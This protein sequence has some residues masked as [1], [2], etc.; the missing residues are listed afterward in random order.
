MVYIEQPVGV[1]FSYS[2][3][4]SDYTMGD[5]STA[6]DT[7]AALLQFFAR[8]PQY[9]GRPFYITGESYGGH[10]VPTL[11]TAIIAYNAA[12]PGSPINMAG[13][14][15]G[16]G[17][18]DE[19]IDF[20]SP[21][22]YFAHHALTSFATYQAALS[23]CANGTFFAPCSG[24]ESNVT[25]PAACNNALTAIS[26][27]VGSAINPYDIYGDL[28]LSE[29]SQERALRVAARGTS[30]GL[31][32][33]KVRGENAAYRMLMASP[34]WKSLAARQQAQVAAAGI[35]SGNNPWLPCIDDYAVTYLN[36]ADVKAAIHANAS[37]T[38]A[39]CSS[40]INY[41]FNHSSMLPLYDAFAANA[42]NMKVLV[43]SGDAD[44]VLPFLGTQWNMMALNRATLSPWTMWTGADGQIGGYLITYEHATYPLKFRTIKG[45][46]HMVAGT[47]PAH[48]LDM[49]KDL[50]GAW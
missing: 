17:L 47:Q 13:I 5:L 11:A 18:T 37:I 23:A 31:G 24:Y 40:S 14:G 48:G 8:Y 45:A 22:T 12:N 15:V 2:N 1:G 4:P 42:P 20:T 3:N 49:F 35:P 41:I 32:S 19:G 26:N 28:C 44:S 21:P 9:A 34:F 43:F 39:E 7:L 46:G 10:Y 27:E 6:Q 29:G 36:R 16:N 50:I 33:G 25:C 38:W 30:A